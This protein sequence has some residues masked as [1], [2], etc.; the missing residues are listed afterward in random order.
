MILGEVL[1]GRGGNQKRKE[2]TEYVEEL[3]VEHDLIDIWRIRNPSEARFTWRQKTPII[4]RR[5]DYWLISDCLQV[6]IDTVDI[7]TG[8]KSDHSA[9]TLGMNGLDES[10]RGP[11]FWKF[12][13]NLVNDADY[14]QLISENYNVWLEE[15]NEV[16]DKR[17]L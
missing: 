7:T 11:S 2:S 10:V 12:N 13:S 1:D 15:F 8:I 6:D 16:L 3:C 9:I 14:C 4:Q 17:V 5:L